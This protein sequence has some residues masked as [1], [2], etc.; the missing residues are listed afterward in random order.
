MNRLVNIPILASRH[1]AGKGDEEA[2]EMWDMWTN[3]VQSSSNNFYKSTNLKHLSFLKGSAAVSKL[4]L[5]DA[6]RRQG[7]KL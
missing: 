6:A 7:S 4:L 1:H 3:L 2:A 5:Q